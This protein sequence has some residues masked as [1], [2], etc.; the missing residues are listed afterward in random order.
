MNRNHLMALASCLMLALITPAA[1]AGAGPAS[2]E[3]VLLDDDFSKLETG[4]LSAPVGA[5]TE[6]H[7]LPEA[8]PRGNWTV[9]CFSSASGRAWR[10]EQ[11][12]SAH[13]VVQTYENTK[14][15]RFHPLLVAG[16]PLWGDYHLTVR[17]KPMAEAAPSGVVFRYRNNRCYYFFGFQK[18]SVVLKRVQ[19]E[20]GKVLAERKCTWQTGQNYE[21]VVTVVGRHLHGEIEGLAA[22]DAEDEVYPAGR[23]GL[24]ADGPTRFYRVKVDTSSDEKQRLDARLAKQQ[25]ELEELRAANPHPVLWKKVKTEGFGAG[26]NLRFGDLDGDGQIDVLIGQVEH[27]GPGD[28]YSELS[29][30]TAMTFDGKILW[31]IG[32]PDPEKWHLT[33]DVGFQVHDIDHDG[34]NEVVLLHESGDHR[35]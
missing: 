7:F 17:L 31:Q 13:V 12:K 22:L 33:N 26:R 8:A 2:T 3:V 4:L 25:R 9:A 11:E 16:D 21:A 15:G 32:K 29:C 35:R 5:H 6:Y 14:A 23:V 30:L 1:G 34:H 28:Q 24:L 19:H 10:V 18:G 27:H 20:E